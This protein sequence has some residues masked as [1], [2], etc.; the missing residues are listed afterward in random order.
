MFTV[1][2]LARLKDIK[3]R[4]TLELPTTVAEQQWVLCMAA[5]LQEPVPVSIVRDAQAKGFITEGV[6][7]C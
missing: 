3:A 7:T 1:S 2:E 5:R 4:T 6:L